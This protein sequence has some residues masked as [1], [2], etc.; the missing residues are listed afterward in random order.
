MG[1]CFVEPGGGGQG[2]SGFRVFL[3]EFLEPSPG[4]VVVGPEIP[5]PAGGV[6]EGQEDRPKND[7]FGG[8]KKKDKGFGR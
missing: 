5:I 6:L 1:L 8:E 7:T 3:S 4:E 2:T